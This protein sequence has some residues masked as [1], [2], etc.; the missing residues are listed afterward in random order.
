MAKMSKANEQ[1]SEKMKDINRKTSH[2]AQCQCGVCGRVF[3]VNKN[4]KTSL[5]LDFG[6]HYGCNENDEGIR[7]AETEVE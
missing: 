4:D 3:Y 2:V 1:E 5:D 7:D 6:C